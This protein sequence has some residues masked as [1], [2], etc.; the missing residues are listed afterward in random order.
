MGAV[1][2]GDIGFNFSPVADGRNKAKRKKTKTENSVREQR[3]EMRCVARVTQNTNQ[4]TPLEVGL[5]AL[6][7][8]Y[9]RASW[10]L[11]AA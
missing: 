1:L 3:I 5:R 6:P 9:Q 4:G 8:N 2:D 7:V 10:S 11:T